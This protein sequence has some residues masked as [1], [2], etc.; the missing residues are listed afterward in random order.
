[1]DSL[2][3]RMYRQG[4]GDCFLLTATTGGT[5][6]HLLLDFGLLLGSPDAATRMTAVAENIREVTGGH[7][8]VLAATHEHWDHI[9]GFIQGQ[10]VL[11][12]L[13]VG[14]VW[15]AWTE[16][17]HDPT[18][19]S[20]GAEKARGIRALAGAAHALQGD[21]ADR[22]ERLLSVLGF[23]GDVGLTGRA[24]TTQAMQWIQQRPAP[25][26]YLSP[27]Q[28]LSALGIQ[29]YVLGPPRDRALIHRSD[30]S[31]AVG[32]VY[33]LADAGQDDGFL[34]AAEA[35]AAA[36]DPDS[37][38]SLDS[39]GLQAFDAFFRLAP[40]VA[41]THPLIGEDYADPDQGWRRIDQDWLGA[42]EVLALNL[43]SNTNNTSLVLA[44]EVGDGQVL[45]FPG[46]AQVGNWLSWQSVTWATEAGPVTGPELL[47]RT[48]LYKVGHHGSHNAT[49]RE[50]GLELM[51]SPDLVAMLPVNRV[52]AAKQR[53]NMPLPGL[54]RR[55]EEKTKGR[56]LDAELGVPSTRPEALT[57]AQWQDFLAHTD[58]QEFWVDHTITWTPSGR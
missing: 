23:Y 49:L 16:D 45:L 54:L 39:P 53:W 24:T 37:P 43:D 48:R 13:T 17:P 9:S 40:D 44:F 20:M 5:A 21:G 34:T 3:V 10:D 28:L 26:R 57:P 29:V 27:G 50:K 19:Q 36:Q 55:L 56:I 52:A 31:V 12:T 41:A 14:E 51:T 33:T 1:V 2:R 8:D 46:D 32:E 18:A 25:V 58:V 6:R 47:A 4:L 7:L 42:A 38:G 11:A 15:L 22:A 35:L 30:P